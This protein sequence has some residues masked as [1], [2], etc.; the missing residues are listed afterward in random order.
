MDKQ[1]LPDLFALA[2]NVDI[3]DYIESFYDVEFDGH[4]FAECP[5][6][7]SSK[8]KAFSVSPKKS[9]VK[10]FSCMPRALGLVDFVMES[11]KCSNHEAAKKI[12]L[13]MGLI[14]SEESGLSEEERVA[15]EEANMKERARLKA[16]RD[17][18]REKEMKEEA[19]LHKNAG[20]RMKKEAP[21]MLEAFVARADIKEETKK[22]IRWSDKMDVW[23]FDYLGYDAKHESVVIVNQN[24]ST[25]EVFNIKHHKKWAWDEMSK[26]YTEGVRSSGK[27]ISQH[28]ST[29][30]PFPMEYFLF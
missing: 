8:T 17:A 15:K 4:N 14:A 25:G 10:C 22:I 26:S 16:L 6:C 24:R 27:W 1:K 19:K 20:E 7:G 11:E 28:G 30:S 3:K 18:K 12:C 21:V 23:Y 5:F 29:M 9:I 13:N 2:K